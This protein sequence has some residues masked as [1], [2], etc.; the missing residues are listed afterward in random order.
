M[1][2][3]PLLAPSAH[4]FLVLL[5]ILPM[6]TDGLFNQAQVE[7]LGSSN[8]EKEYHDNSICYNKNTF[9]GRNDNSYE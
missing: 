5:S 1:F 6:Q 4:P 7:K 8:F 9:D 2:F 3:R